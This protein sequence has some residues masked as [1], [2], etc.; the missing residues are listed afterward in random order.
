MPI[1]NPDQIE[2]S[3]STFLLDDAKKGPI[4]LSTQVLNAF[5]L[6]PGIELF[7][8]ESS[9]EY[10]HLIK[11]TNDPMLARLLAI[12][13]PL[14]SA[15]SFSSKLLT[16][17][18][19]V[20]DIIIESIV[21]GEL[22]TGNIQSLLV[23]VFEYGR[24]ILGMMSGTFIALYSPE[25][26]ADSFLTK[27]VDPSISFLSELEAARLYAMVDLLHKFFIKHHIDYRICCGTAL[28]AKREG[29]IIRNDDDIDL[30]LHP[31]SIEAFKV[32]VEDGIFTKETGISIERQ[33]WTGGWQSFY[34]DTPKGITGSPL[35]H[36]GKPFIDIFPGTWRQKG[37]R[38]VI[39]YGEDR[40][41]DLSRN[42]YFTEEEWSEP[43]VL[44]PFGPT[45]LY[46][47]KSIEDYIKRAYGQLALKYVLA[48]I[49]HDALA[50]ISVSPL[51][52]CSI[53]ARHDIPRAM[54]HIEKAPTSF[55][56]L[57]YYERT[58][59]WVSDEEQ[60]DVEALGITA[61]SY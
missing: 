38:Q 56:E 48:A 23:E 45:Q 37:N 1:S 35:E 16:D 28:G 6:Y 9:Y 4:P 32:L 55:D 50:E 40:M 44:Y 11:S 53:F 49:P 43:A 31:D 58:A 24:Y 42:D 27:P 22:A 8:K 34:A 19:S 41:Y 57:E 51:A 17:L 47:I 36:I 15:L 3:S 46:G 29:G 2:V 30:M 7:G 26:A 10:Y 18:C 20:V 25:L 12:G 60:I 5:R 39:S 21:T 13:I 14:S 61:I 33:P 52:T 59:H 54:R